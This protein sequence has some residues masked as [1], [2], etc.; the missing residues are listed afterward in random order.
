MN[1]EL[2]ISLAETKS[3][4]KEWTKENPKNQRWATVLTAITKLQVHLAPKAEDHLE[5]EVELEEDH[6]ETLPKE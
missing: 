3:L 4:L 5:V 2:L 1:D 6:N